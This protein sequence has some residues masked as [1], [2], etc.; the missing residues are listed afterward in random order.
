MC[1]NCDCL[2][3]FDCNDSNGNCIPL[4]FANDG[5]DD[6][7]DGSDEGTIGK[8]IPCGFR[9]NF[10]AKTVQRHQKLLDPF[11]CFTLKIV[12]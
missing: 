1:E 11:T 6:C 8:K 2:N 4:E 7:A 9:N 10:L 3:E 12:P 5:E